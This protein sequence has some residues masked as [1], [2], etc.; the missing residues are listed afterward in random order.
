[1]LHLGP[2]LGSLT[3]AVARRRY[4]R[5]YTR[6]HDDLDPE[7]HL[8]EAA[9]W[10]S[11]AQDDGADDG[12]AYGTPF[13]KSFLPSYPE[14]TGYIIP[15]FLRLAQVWNDPGLRD[16]AARMGDWEIAIQMP[17]GAVMGGMA[18]DAPSP[19]VFNT[20]QVLQGWAA[21]ATETGDPRYVAAGR[22]AAEWLVGIQRVVETGVHARVAPP[23]DGKRER[24]EHRAQVKHRP[25]G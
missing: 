23:C 12:V 16:R 1:M 25:P 5:V 17:C 24:T 10:L 22:R 18:T 6:L 15:T 9:A 4:A 11:R 14:T 7:T 13:G 19:A 3:F 20:G 8:R 2:V 21:L